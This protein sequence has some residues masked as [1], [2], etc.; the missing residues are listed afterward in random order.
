[1]QRLQARDLYDIWYLLDIHEMDANFYSL[2]FSDK[3]KSKGLSSSEFSKK[4]LERMPQYKS[5]WQASI[6]TQIKNLPDFEQV[7]R[8]VTKGLKGFL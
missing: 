2:E 8:A 3:C 7:Q 6:N 1:M 4:L 5:R